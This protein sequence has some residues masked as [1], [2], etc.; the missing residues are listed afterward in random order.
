MRFLQYKDSPDWWEWPEAEQLIVYNI[1]GGWHEINE[2]S[3]GFMYGKVVNAESWAEL[4]HKEHYNPWKTNTPTAEMWIDP[5]GVMYNCGEWGAHEVTAQKILENYFGELVGFWD[6]GDQLIDR[7]WIKVSK[8]PMCRYYFESNM[9][10]NITD[11]QWE[12]LELW[13]EKYKK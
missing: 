12:A 13:K 2:N 9:Y 4:C 1:N 7:G 8:G 11:K 6:C 10:D 5:D 3:E